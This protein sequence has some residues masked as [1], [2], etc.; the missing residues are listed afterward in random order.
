MKAEKRN[1][2][3]MPDTGDWSLVRALERL[4]ELDEPYSLSS[5]LAIFGCGLVLAGF[6]GGLRAIVG[7]HPYL[8]ALAFGVVCLGIAAVTYK[9]GVLR[10]LPE[11][12]QTVLVDMTFYDL[13][14]DTSVA[15]NF[16]RRWGRLL[17]LCSGEHSEE[18]VEA[19]IKDVDP[20]FLD[21]VFNKSVAHFL[22]P[23]PIRQLL[24]PDA[25]GAVAQRTTREIDIQ[26]TVS[27]AAI[28]AIVN[29]KSEEIRQKVT[30]PDWTHVIN[31]AIAQV[32]IGTMVHQAAMTGMGFLER[33]SMATSAVCGVSAMVFSSPA[34]SSALQRLVF[35]SEAASP[36]PG[37]I[38]RTIVKLSLLGAGASL[39]LSL[40]IRFTWS[41]RERVLRHTAAGSSPPLS[42]RSHE[43]EVEESPEGSTDDECVPNQSR[44]HLRS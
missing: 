33:F 27:P 11:I 12:F 42:E 6:L 26:Q 24:L 23:E 40:G 35:R 2:A 22:F 32:T 5:S 13:F 10:L 20:E 30:E 31:H 37:G 25:P 21:I 38:A 34:A 41:P 43:P 19:I 39:A 14:S 44:D 16:M 18:R 17:F 9:G 8:L 29:K 15:T 36:Q 3:V 7:S 1:L 28:Q 4:R